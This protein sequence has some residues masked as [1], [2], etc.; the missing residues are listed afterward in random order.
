MRTC[1][2]AAAHRWALPRRA[3]KESA[4]EVRAP[5]T[6]TPGLLLLSR[7]DWPHGQLRCGGFVPNTGEDETDSVTGAVRGHRRQRYSRQCSHTEV[8][9]CLDSWLMGA[10]QVCGRASSRTEVSVLSETFQNSKTD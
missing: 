10:L 3:S 1:A 6:P 4:R 9:L 5:K 7:V 8:Q 2:P